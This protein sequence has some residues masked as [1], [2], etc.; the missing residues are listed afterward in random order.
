MAGTADGITR[1]AL[2]RSAGAALGFASELAISGFAPAAAQGESPSKVMIVRHAEK[3]D[4]DGD[5]PFGLGPDGRPDVHGLLVRGWE[6]AGALARFFAPRDGA[7]PPAGLARPTFLFAAGPTPEHP[8]RRSV[9][10]LS[11][12]AELTGL[13]PDA[14]FGPDHAS[15]AA[16][17]ILR[18]GGV[19]LVAWEHKRIADLVGAVTGG[20][21]AGPHWPGHR[22]DMVLALDRD[23]AG[24]R[25]SQVP[26]LLLAGD[27]AAP[28]PMR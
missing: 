15:E 19:G 13:V 5:A 14:S 4:R 23:G 3:P 16:V 22:F 2:V 11:A 25:L 20:T 1:R 26:Q 8:S 6:R 7:G 18:R 17:A 10:T 28:L 9:L 27:S 12:L 24:W 21:V